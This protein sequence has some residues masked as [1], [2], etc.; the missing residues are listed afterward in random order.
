M[1]RLGRLGKIIHLL[2]TAAA[3][4]PAALEEI[5]DQYEDADQ[6]LVGPLLASFDAIARVPNSAAGSLVSLARQTVTEMIEADVPGVRGLDACLVELRR[7]MLVSGDSVQDCLVTATSANAGTPVGTG[8]VVLTTKRGDG[9]V[10]ENLIAEVGRLTCTADS[11]TGGRTAGQESFTYVGARNLASTFDHDWPQGSNASL[12]LT[13]VSPG[14]DASAAGNLLTNGDFEDW[15]G[16]PLQ[17]EHWAISGG[18]WATEVSQNATGISGFGLLFA[19]AAT[20]RVYTVFDSAESTGA[21]AGTTAE[22]TP[23]R[24]YAVNLWLRRSAAALGAGTLRVRLTDPNNNVVA[25]EQ[26]VDNSFTIDLTTLTTAYTAFNGVFRLPAVYTAP[27]KLE[28]TVTVAAD[29]SFLLDDV[30]FAPLSAPAASGLGTG[31]GVAVFRGATAWKAGD[32]KDITTTNDRGAATYNATFQALILRLLGRPGFL[33][34]SAGVPTIL[35]DL[36]TD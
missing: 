15:T 4:L 23:L 14:Q 3:G 1:V 25:D 27:A 13:C 19:A 16:S 24:S 36:I 28:I 32:A 35:D 12:T 18:A 7:Q 8:V 26:G 34:P 29:Q 33:L 11:H 10:Q 20:P 22:P 2:N 21:D 6:S 30:A 9:L 5:H 17:P 31:P